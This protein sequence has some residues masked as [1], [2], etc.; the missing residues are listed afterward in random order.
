MFTTNYKSH[1]P[2]LKSFLGITQITTKAYQVTKFNQSILICTISMS[3]LFTQP[4]RSV[5]CIRPSISVH[6]VICNITFFRKKSFDPI[7]G[8]R[9]SKRAEHLLARCSMLHS[10]YYDMQQDYFQLR[11]QINL[12]TPP[13]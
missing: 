6:N 13:Q 4:K 2:Q 11:K 10:N 7:Q 1:S 8:S 5:V 9:V 3:E 12:L